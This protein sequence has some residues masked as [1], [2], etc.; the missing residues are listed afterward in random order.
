MILKKIGIEAIL[1]SHTNLKL[2]LIKK[3]KE[4]GF[5]DIKISKPDLPN[6]V[7]NNYLEFIQKGLH[8][9]MNWLKNRAEYRLDSRLLMEDVRS[10]IMLAVNYT[11]EK[12]PIDL[13]EQKERGL[14]SVYAQG[15][16][17]HVFIKKNLKKLASW[18]KLNAGGNVKVFLDT[19]PVLE[20]PFAQNSGLGWQGKHT[21][22]VS[23]K[24]GSWM[25]LG[26]IFTSLEFE[27]DTP[28]ED[29]CGTCSRCLDICP[30]NAFIDPYKIDARKC[31]SYLTIEYKGHIPLKFRKPIGNR[32][33]GC[34]DC[35][36]VC[37]WNKFSVAPQDDPIS[38]RKEL[39]E[40]Y[41]KDFICF[42]DTYF[43]KYF[44]KSPIKRIGRN[45]FI[46]NVLIA[47]GNSEKKDLVENILPLL[48]D[49][50]NLVRAMS[51]WALG[52]LDLLEA[53]KVKPHY[54]KKETDQYVL[55][56]WMAI[57]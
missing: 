5:D 38:I 22:L 44:S 20:K 13:I 55:S 39:E 53:K 19:A 1:K 3:A 42:D 45:R 8:G 14:I 2:E 57:K 41:L 50:S 33:Y 54:I 18:L 7:S 37:P 49:T 26:E 47:I 34:D 4:F 29:H 15:I 36:A 40:M 52:E 48:S 31:I 21:N 28:E 11:P 27:I 24:F 9:E 46:R 16:D 35:L 12:N 6:H 17:Y 56:E 43:R 10:I 32:I 30:T 23:K 25:F 51:V